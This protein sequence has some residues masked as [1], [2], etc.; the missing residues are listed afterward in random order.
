MCAFR[1]SQ[2]MLSAHMPCQ[3]GTPRSARSDRTL[4]VTAASS[5]GCMLHGVDGPR[6]SRFGWDA[7]RHGMPCRADAIQALHVT[8]VYLVRDHVEI[9]LGFHQEVGDHPLIL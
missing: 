9:G 2:E 3:A 1:L 4:L 5:V 7:V 6:G 8:F